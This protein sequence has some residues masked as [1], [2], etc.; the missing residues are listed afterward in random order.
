MGV[1]FQY[2]IQKKPNGIAEALLIGEKFLNKSPSALILGDNL[3]H[4]TNL[5][6]KLI[7]ANK[8]KDGG[9][10]FA[11]QVA[12]PKCY[13]VVEFDSHR[14]ALSIEEKPKIPKKFLCSY[15]YIFL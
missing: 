4:G 14:K 15:W 1:N 6:E 11:Y 5:I 3:F 7:K 12:D 8:D 10:I 9:T 2:E 13:G